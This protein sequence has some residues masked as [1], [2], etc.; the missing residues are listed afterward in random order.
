MHVIA[1]NIQWGGRNR[2][3]RIAET[4]EAKSPDVIVLTEYQTAATAPLLDSLRHKRWLHQVLSSPPH[5]YGGV[6]IVSRHRLDVGK[7]P[8]PLASFAW[9]YLPVSVPA[10]G[11]EVVGLYGPLQKDLPDSFW[12][13]ALDGLAAA[14]DRSVLVVGDFNTGESLVD[15]PVADFF[16]SDFFRDLPARGYTDLWRRRVGRAARDY[17][18]LGRQNPYRLDHAFGTEAIVERLTDCTY[19]HGERETLVSDHSLLSIKLRDA[20][21]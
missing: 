21:F 16:C 17:S 3:D 13:G 19:S 10:F 15:T 20:G 5:R 8:D 14:S 9:R 12:R 2:L 1:W 11:V 18:W 7:R 6:A 4:L